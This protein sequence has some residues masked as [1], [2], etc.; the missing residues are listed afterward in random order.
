MTKEDK[1][2]LGMWKL[3][4]TRRISRC[5]DL[6]EPELELTNFYYKCSEYCRVDGD[7][8]GRTLFFNRYI[9]LCGLLKITSH[10][11]NLDIP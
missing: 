8:V 5:V 1:D 11:V 6:V 3:N 9:E 7:G 10:Y 4:D 2:E